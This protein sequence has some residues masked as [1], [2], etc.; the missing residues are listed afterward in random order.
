M[1][2]INDTSRV[3][4]TYCGTTSSMSITKGEKMNKKLFNDTLVRFQK[5][6]HDNWDNVEFKK[7]DTSE[8]QYPNDLSYRADTKSWRIDINYSQS[9]DDGKIQKVADRSMNTYL[10]RTLEDGTRIYKAVYVFFNDS[11]GKLYDYDIRTTVSV[12]GH[13]IASYGT[14]CN[15]EEIYDYIYTSLFYNR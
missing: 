13:H 1:Q 3:H 7:L 9:D 6:L 11:Y 14:K 2:K 5:Q 12:N 8:F 10:H 15:A 4:T